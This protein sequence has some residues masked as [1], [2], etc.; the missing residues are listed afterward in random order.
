MRGWTEEHLGW[1]LREWFDIALL[2]INVKS[3]QEAR[4][5]IFF[6]FSRSEFIV[7]I[8]LIAGPEAD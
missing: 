7:Y 1:E 5:I 6:F 3:I 8:L 4:R 2:A